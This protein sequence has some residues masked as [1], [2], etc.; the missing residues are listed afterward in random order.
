F[1]FLVLSFMA[2]RTSAQVDYA[3]RDPK[4]GDDT[5]IADLLK[6]LTLD[7][8]VELMDGHT[9]IPRLHLV[10][11]DEAEG[12]RGLALG[13]PGRWGPRGR[14]PL[15]TTTFPQE[16]GLGETWDTALMKKIG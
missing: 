14:E 1:F 9:K 15:P 6:R 12:L 11:S 13:G 4:L 16:K 10:L 8:K 3:F 7:E 2:L 5:R